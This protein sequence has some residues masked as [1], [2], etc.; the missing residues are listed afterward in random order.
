M[1]GKQEKISMCKNTAI[2]FRKGLLTGS[3]LTWSDSG[4]INFES[5]KL[6]R[7][8]AVFNPVQSFNWPDVIST[9]T[10]CG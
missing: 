8:A 5:V 6:I 4:V 3:G 2:T 1:P 9:H 7:N 10:H